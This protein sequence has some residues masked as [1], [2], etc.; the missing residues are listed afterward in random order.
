VG[1]ELCRPLP[2]LAIVGAEQKRHKGSQCESRIDLHVSFPR[3]PPP[4]ASASAYGPAVPSKQLQS[5]PVLFSHRFTSTRC[6]RSCTTPVK[7]GKRK[8]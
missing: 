8:R 4:V 6:K 1:D 2:C 7:P 3:L 5:T